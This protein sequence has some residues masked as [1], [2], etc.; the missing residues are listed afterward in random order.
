VKEFN[1]QVENNDAFKSIFMKLL[2]QTR[3]LFN[4]DPLSILSMS[5]LAFI[6]YFN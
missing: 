4:T 1:N 2:I 5:I 6:D 3:Q